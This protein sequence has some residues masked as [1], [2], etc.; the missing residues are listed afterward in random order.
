MSRSV[1]DI[2]RTWPR[3]TKASAR[4][5]SHFSSS[6]QAPL[7]AQFWPSRG[8][9]VSVASIGRSPG[10]SG[11]RSRCIIHCFPPVWN[12][13]Y[14]PVARCPCSLTLTSRF[15]HFSVSYLPWSQMVTEP[16]PYSPRGICP[17]KRPYSSGW[18][19]V[20]TA[21]WFTAGSSG[22]P[23]G[24]AQDTSTPSRSSRKS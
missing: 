17:S 15:V 21:R 13:A 18:S 14:P 6:A 10:G 11:W 23:F 19:S 24:T 2:R 1:L 4:T 8:A 5:P 9:D 20:C 16:A 3:S 12:N 22:S 7:S